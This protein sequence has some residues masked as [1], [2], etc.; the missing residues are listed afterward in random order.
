MEQKT[1]INIYKRIMKKLICYLTLNGKKHLTENIFLKISKTLQKRS[2]KNSKNLMKL[3]VI[4][5]TQ[6]FKINA[7]AK[8]KIFSILYKSKNR[9]FSAIK[10]IVKTIKKEKSNVFYKT[11]CKEILFVLK[12]D[13]FILT[14]KKHLQEQVFFK[15]HFF[16]YYRWR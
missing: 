3:S 10:F 5:S 9:T 16:V 11:F 6:V 15:K 13:S 14:T 8:S 2:N 4:F 12:N 1:Y 7:L